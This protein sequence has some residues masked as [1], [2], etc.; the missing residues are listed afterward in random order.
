MNPAILLAALALAAPAGRDSALAEEY[1]RLAR[2]TET[3][4]AMAK[5]AETELAASV[6]DAECDAVK[7]IL[8]DRNAD[9]MRDSRAYLGSRKLHDATV[10]LLQDTY[11]DAE[12]AQVNEALRSPGGRVLAEKSPRLTMK[13]LDV[14][15]ESD[16]DAD[17]RAD[18]IDTKYRSRFE[19]VRAQCEAQMP[20]GQAG[21]ERDDGDRGRGDERDD[22]RYDDRRDERDE[23]R[24]AP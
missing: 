9:I 1:L 14:M 20:R 21:D 17:R 2:V 4:D 11:T 7:P 24:R 8:R 19:A 10:K 15:H 18:A 23:R 6:D 5:Q 16:A 22:D 12:L 3:F 13:L